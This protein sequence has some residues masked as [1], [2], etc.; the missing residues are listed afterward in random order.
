MLLQYFFSLVLILRC[1]V[2][3]FLS[4]FLYSHN[5]HQSHLMFGPNAILFI[6]SSAIDL[7]VHCYFTRYLLYTSVIYS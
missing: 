4:F 3:F 7:W 6:S 1:I 2:G 5:Y